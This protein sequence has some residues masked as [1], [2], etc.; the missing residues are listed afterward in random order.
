M[1]YAKPSPMLIMDLDE[2]LVSKEV[3][4]EVNRCYPSVATVQIRT[5]AAPEGEDACNTMRLMVLYGMRDYLYSSKE[6]A[7]EL[8]NGVVEHWLESMF[9]KV[10]NQMKIYNRRQREI[11]GTEL[12]FSYLVVE[13]QDGEF[14]VALHLDS[15]SDISA[16]CV[17]FITQVRTLLNEGALGENVTRVQM[18]SDTSYAAQYEAGMEAKAQR[19][20]QAEAEAEAVAQAEAEAAAQAEAEAEEAF[21]ESPEL[22]EEVAE[23]ERGEDEVDLEQLGYEIEKMYS[24]PEVD[25]ALDYHM[26]DVAYAD[27]TVREYDSEAGAFTERCR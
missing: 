20:A 14:E 25:F 9:Y 7:D 22:T 1:T 19:E 10:A 16:A 4:E 27:G 24:F 23:A 2:R 6:G 15:N 21:L 13:L 3:R 8:W 18:P 11:E 12:N 5:H 17:A 26:W